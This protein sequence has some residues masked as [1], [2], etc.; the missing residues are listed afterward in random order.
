MGARLHAL[1]AQRDLHKQPLEFET[2][3]FPDLSGLQLS[4]S[5]TTKAW[6]KNYP[7]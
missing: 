7:V 1:V 6:E 5:I 2:A 4:R 3:F